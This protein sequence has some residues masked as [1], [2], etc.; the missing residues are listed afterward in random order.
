M[1]LAGEAILWSGNHVRGVILS[2]AKNLLDTLEIRARKVSLRGLL[3]AA[4]LIFVAHFLEEAPGFVAWF[5]AHVARGVTEQMFWTVNYT[6]LAI[7]LAVVALAWLDGS[8]LS[9]VAVVAW[10]SLLFGANALLHLTATAMDRAPM[11]GVVT[12]VVLYLPFYAWLM[13]LVAQA[14]RLTRSAIVGAALVGATPML[15][16]GYLVIF[17][18]TRLF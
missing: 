13:R 10:F 12:A 14:R 6:G 5:N 3:L 2:E 15:A 7:T 17:R 16:H 11:P 9:D 1:R 8:A 18:G 4:P